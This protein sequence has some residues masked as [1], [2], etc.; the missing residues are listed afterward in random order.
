MPVYSY[1]A[2]GPGAAIVRGLVTADSPFAARQSLRQRGLA[3]SRLA[4]CRPKRT[5]IGRRVS[6]LALSRWC[7]D[8]ATLLMVGL[9][10]PEA[11][12]SVAGRSPKLL[13][14][15]GLSLAQD[16][17]SGRPLSDAMADAPQAFDELSVSLARAGEESGQLEKALS[18]LGD[19]KHRSSRFG[20]ALF[21]SLLYPLLVA[22]MGIVVALFLMTYVLPGIIEPLTELGKPL[23]AVTRVVKGASDLLIGYGW[24]LLIAVPLVIWAAWSLWNRPSVRGRIERWLLR[25]P[26]LGQ[27]IATKAALEVSSVLATLHSSGVGLTRALDIAAGTLSNRTIAQSLRRASAAVLE[28]REAASVLQADGLFPPVFVHGLAIGQKTGEL[29]STLVRLSG[30]LEHELNT[31]SQRLATVL[32]PLVIVVLATFVLIICMATLLPILEAGNVL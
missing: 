4:E 2:F 11:L 16:V 12:S 9:P 8:L 3:A 31:T 22:L 27:A 18:Q 29:D 20:S 14:R 1:R 6:P 15:I 10:L 32:E 25:V 28:G 7:R 21:T 13:S 24:T 30:E 26:V 23:P 19:F 5:R 17:Q